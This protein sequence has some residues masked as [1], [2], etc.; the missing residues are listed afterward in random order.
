MEHDTK[1][2]RLAMNYSLINKVGF[3]CFITQKKT[4]SID[5]SESHI[6]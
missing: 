6:L 4:K 3:Q 1:P 2:C 5:D